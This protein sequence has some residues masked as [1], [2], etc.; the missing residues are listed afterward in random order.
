MA[1]LLLLILG[2]QFSL[3]LSS[4]NRLFEKHDV[5]KE[6]CAPICPVSFGSSHLAVNHPRAILLMLPH[7]ASGVW[8]SHSW[9][10][11]QFSVFS[12]WHRKNL[13]LDE[14]KKTECYL[15][16]AKAAAS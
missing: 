9:G 11:V 8:G 14:M 15:V 2:F 5:C 7:L 16:S 12:N 1:F 6:N 13:A 10:S 3:G 4:L